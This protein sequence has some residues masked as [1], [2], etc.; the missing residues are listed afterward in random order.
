MTFLCT[1]GLILKVEHYARGSELETPTVQG[2]LE[3]E[4]DIY[5]TTE[6]T[7][8]EQ[9]TTMA[10]LLLHLSGFPLP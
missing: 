7:T 3:T 1:L 6:L 2:M 8:T 9:T 10:Q 4:N 5:N